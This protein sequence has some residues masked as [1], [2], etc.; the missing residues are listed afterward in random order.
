M[1]FNWF[2]PVSE[3]CIDGFCT[4]ASE[5]ITHR[6]NSLESNG[7]AVAAMNGA[8]RNG[9]RTLTKHREPPASGA[10]VMQRDGLRIR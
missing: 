1:L 6:R 2:K 7:W 8:Q 9:L 3:C 10:R 4:G 5:K